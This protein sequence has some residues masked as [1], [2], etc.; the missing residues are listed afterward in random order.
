LNSGFKYRLVRQ[1]YFGLDLHIPDPEQVKNKYE[2]DRHNGVEPEFPFWSRAWPS[3]I[4]LSHFIENDPSFVTGRK[5]IELGA[6]LAIPS[7]VASRYAS[8]VLATD[9]LDEA[10]VLMDEN[11]NA[12]KLGNVKAEKLNWNDLPGIIQADTVIMSDLN[13][14]PSEFSRLFAIIQNFL[15]SG[16][17][18][19]LATP[20][21]LMAK[22]FIESLMSYIRFWQTMII[23]DTEILIVVLKNQALEKTCSKTTP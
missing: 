21:R 15:L 7:F 10:V 11:I 3:S 8:A 20:Q 6:G 2:A 9:Y 13:Y 19:L 22:S 23:N 16:S 5:I 14:W 18:I 1:Q 17:T 4:A 12:L